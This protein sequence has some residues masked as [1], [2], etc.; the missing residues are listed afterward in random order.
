MLNQSPLPKSF[1]NLE[2]CISG[3]KSGY[4]EG[5]YNALKEAEVEHRLIYGKVVA[6]ATVEHSVIS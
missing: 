1:E 5:H 2:L 4:S 3:Q 6:A